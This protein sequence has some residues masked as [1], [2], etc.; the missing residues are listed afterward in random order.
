M[1]ILQRTQLNVKEDRRLKRER[2][3]ITI[4]TNEPGE[5]LPPNRRSAESDTPVESR[6]ETERT[7]TFWLNTSQGYGIFFGISVTKPFTVY[8][9]AQ[10]S[11][12]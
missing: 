5:R 7:F 2:N 6:R 12:N 10:D 11:Y 3:E 4:L 9:T 8:Y 1:T